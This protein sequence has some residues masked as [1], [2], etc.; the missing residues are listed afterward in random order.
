MKQ[1]N[2]ELQ[3]RVRLNQVIINLYFFLCTVQQSI[4]FDASLNV[5][6]FPFVNQDCI[7]ELLPKIEALQS[8]LT[9]AEDQIKSLCN[10]VT[11][12][13]D[14]VQ[15]LDTKLQS[16]EVEKRNILEESSKMKDSL[17]ADLHSQQKEMS[18]VKQANLDLQKN[19]DKQANKYQVKILS[20]LLSLLKNLNFRY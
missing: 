6:I 2:L 3:H 9:D 16:T 14:Q 10:E 11:T 5:S 4:D 15:Q 20:G 18:A 19:S 8:S 1:Q 13:K 12:S 17:L 7:S